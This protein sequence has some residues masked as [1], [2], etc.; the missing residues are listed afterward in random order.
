MF[1][2]VCLQISSDKIQYKPKKIAISEIPNVIA[3]FGVLF[4]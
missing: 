1:A 4:H 2:L 3:F